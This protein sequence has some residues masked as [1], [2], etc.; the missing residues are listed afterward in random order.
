MCISLS[1]SIYIY[2]YNLR[3]THFINLLN[4]ISGGGVSP[5][6]P[7]K[8]CPWWR[9]IR[10]NQRDPNP[11]DNSLIREQPS[12]RHCFLMK[13][14]LVG[15]GSLR[16]GPI[17]IYI[18]IYAYH[19]FVSYIYI[20]IYTYFLW[21]SCLFKQYLWNCLIFLLGQRARS[22]RGR[23]A[24]ASAIIMLTYIYIY[25]YI[26][27]IGNSKANHNNN[28]NNTNTTNNSNDT[29]TNDNGNY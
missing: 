2:I 26:Y 16:V 20:Y 12:T 29:N 22:A 7:P 23:S 9:P 5:R 8:S 3:P 14:F 1:L 25:I 21:F 13:E 11:K 27:I 4:L 10:R 6:G 15:V 17:Y 19:L 28:T 24:C 18:Y